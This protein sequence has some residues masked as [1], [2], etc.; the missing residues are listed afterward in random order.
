LV[1]QNIS[2][3]VEAIEE[4][5]SVIRAKFRP[6]L[7]NDLYLEDVSRLVEVVPRMLDNVEALTK[8]LANAFEALNAATRI[9]K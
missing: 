7:D 4:N 3:G 1:T 9:D 5:I 8:E 6:L 2:G